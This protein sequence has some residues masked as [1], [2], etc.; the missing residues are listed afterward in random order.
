ME[1]INNLT[2]SELIAILIFVESVVKVI[3]LY[4]NKLYNYKRNEEKETEKI[5]KLDKKLQDLEEKV[6]N[7]EN[8]NELIIEVLKIQCRFYIV[9]SCLNQIHQGHIKSE[10][11][12]SI[13]DLYK[14]Y[15]MLGGN[16]YVSDLVKRLDELEIE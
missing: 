13:K 14:V 2:I 12:Q 10:K 15:K 6:E 5:K 7:N 3:S 9:D 16:S 11:L 1:Y 8:E 4:F